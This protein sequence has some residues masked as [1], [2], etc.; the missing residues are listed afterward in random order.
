MAVVLLGV[1]VHVQHGIAFPLALHLHDVQ[2][3]KE[4][5][6]AL[7]V[8]LDGAVLFFC[9]N[10]NNLSIA[11]KNIHKNACRKQEAAAHQDI[12]AAR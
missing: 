1:Q 8:G 12:F 4:L 9:K 3:L 10:T 2:S 7:E 5:A 11:P 6:L